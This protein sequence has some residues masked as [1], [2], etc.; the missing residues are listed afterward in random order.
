GAVLGTGSTGSVTLLDRLG[1]TEFQPREVSGTIPVG[2]TSAV[3]PATFTDRCPVLGNYND[4][5]ADNLSFTVGDPNLTPAQ[6][7]I[8]TSNVGHIDHV[9]VIYMENHGVGD[10]IGSPN[11]PFINSLINSQDYVSNFFAL[12]HPSD[13]NYFRILG[14]SDFGIAYN[15]PS[16]G[17]INAPSLMQ[18]MDQNG[19]SWAGY[20]QSM[21]FP[22]ATMPS[23]NYSPD[24][25]PF[26]QFGYVFN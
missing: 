9:Q 5:Y 6:L 11:A 2:T 18:E 1:F 3:V 17:L 7:T 13:P 10:I 14:G 15:P 22:G 24:Q 19:M 21:P 4:A 12:S 16:N 25:L 8:P 20:A 23:G 26:L